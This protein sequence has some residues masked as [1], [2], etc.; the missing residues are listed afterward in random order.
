MEKII[1]YLLQFVLVSM[2]LFCGGREDL[3]K[4][5]TINKDELKTYF[6]TNNKCSVKITNFGA[7]VMSI[8]VPDK[9]GTI[10]D[11]VLGYDTPEEYI[12]GNPY[13]G[14]TIGRYGNRISEGKFILDERE[15]TLPVNNGNNHLHGGPQGFHNVVWKVKDYRNDN[16]QHFLV[17]DYVSKDGEQGYPGQV[18]VTVKYSLTDKNELVIDYTA[19]TDK[20]TIIN[21]T[22]HSFFNLKDGGESTIL[23]HTLKILAD[24]F[25]PVTSELIPTGEIKSVED[26]PMDFTECT[27]IGK[28][29]NNDFIQLTYGTGYDHNWVLNKKTD[30]LEL[31]A[32]VCEPE[33]GR[34]M[35]VFTTEPGLQFYSGNFLDGSDQ[36]KQ[37]V[38]YEYRTAFCLEAQHFPDSPNYKNFPSTVLQPGEKYT[39]RTIY[40][41]STIE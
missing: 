22:H 17:L 8:K 40:K 19:F 20:K 34:K 5:K 23:N 13:F 27:E 1:S 9:N 36:G 33:S 15:Y 30:S 24:K 38:R 28:R 14:A 2:F 3:N 37:G 26:T 31:A 32:V 6:L 4:M 29:I 10:K 35:E 41:F 21:L 12:E 18:K 39:Q 16:D 25:T 11:V 7:S